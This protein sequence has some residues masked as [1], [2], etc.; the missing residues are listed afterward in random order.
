MGSI[1]S[2]PFQDRADESQAAY[3]MQFRDSCGFQMV[4][5][6]RETF[7]NPLDQLEISCIYHK[8]QGLSV[9]PEPIFQL[10]FLSATIPLPWKQLQVT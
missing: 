4:Q 7:Y 8:N 6:E 3:T 2:S 5:I 10:C 1:C 9:V